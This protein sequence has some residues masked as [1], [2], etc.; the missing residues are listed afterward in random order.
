MERGTE[1]EWEAV[2][3]AWRAIEAR[4]ARTDALLLGSVLAGS[5]FLIV[6]FALLVP[7][8]LCVHGAGIDGSVWTTQRL[9]PTPFCSH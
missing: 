6:A 4:R 1:R 5:G 8:D 9:G 2:R 7:L 3:E